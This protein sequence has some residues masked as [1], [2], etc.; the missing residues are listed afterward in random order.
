MNNLLRYLFLRE[1]S[2]KLPLVNV[3]K[4]DGE[5]VLAV[6]CSESGLWPRMIQ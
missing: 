4:L 5:A 3:V 6:V 1:T 2:T